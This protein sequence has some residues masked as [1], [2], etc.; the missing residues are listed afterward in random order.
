MLFAVPSVLARDPA[1]PLGVVPVPVLAAPPSVSHEEALALVAARHAAAAIL[2]VRSPPGSP[3]D[4]RDAARWSAAVAAV[5]ALPDLV[6]ARAVD[7]FRATHRCA[8]LAHCP[9]AS[10][11]RHAR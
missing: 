10:R 2:I 9:L 6:R 4:P 11:G 5:D 8:R 1:D 3:C 7:A